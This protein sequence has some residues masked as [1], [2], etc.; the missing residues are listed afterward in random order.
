LDP[1][2]MEGEETPVEFGR[3]FLRARNSVLSD[4][5]GLLP[6]EIEKYLRERVVQ[7]DFTKA[8]SEAFTVSMC[9]YVDKNIVQ[10][11][12]QI[13]KKHGLLPGLYEGDSDDGKNGTSEIQ[14]TITHS[15]H[16]QRGRRPSWCTLP[17]ST[18]IISLIFVA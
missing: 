14:N 10:K 11:L 7:T 4:E 9:E 18:L 1:A 6:W 2:M 16:L 15:Q 3:N 13:R 8:S 5:R 17:Q 12:A